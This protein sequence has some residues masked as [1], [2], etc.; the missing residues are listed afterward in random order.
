MSK[1]GNNRSNDSRRWSSEILIKVQIV[2]R[3]DKHFKCIIEGKSNKNR[4]DLE[5]VKAH[6]KGIASDKRDEDFNNSSSVV[7]NRVSMIGEVPL[8]RLND[9]DKT[10]NIRDILKG[11]G[12]IVKIEAITTTNPKVNITSVNHL[13][14]KPT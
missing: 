14:S 6:S 13:T 1:Q 7:N 5:V 3:G 8:N 4:M 11:M 12:D 10:N 2:R 9:M